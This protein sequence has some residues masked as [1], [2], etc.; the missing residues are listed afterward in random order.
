M[1]DQRALFHG[2]IT[3]KDCGARSR[4]GYRVPDGLCPESGAH[5]WAPTG[6]MEVAD[7]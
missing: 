4:S 1:V 2:D 3:C 7:A 6:D 5:R